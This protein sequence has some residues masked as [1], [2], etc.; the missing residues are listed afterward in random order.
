MLQSWP[1][2][3]LDGVTAHAQSVTVT[4]TAHGLEVRREG[5]G[6]VVWPY[7]DVSQTQGNYRG[8]HVRLERGREPAEAIIVDD[9]AF[10]TQL[11]KVAPRAAGRFHNPSSR[12]RRPAL[13]VMALVAAIALGAGI[14]FWAIPATATFVAEQVPVAWEEEL[15]RTVANAMIGS[16]AKCTDREVTRTVEDIVTRLAATVPAN[17]YTFRVSVIADET[18]NA[19]AAPGGHIVV[20]AGLLQRTERAEELAGVLAHEISHVVRRHGTKSL[21][22]SVAT[23]VFLSAVAGDASGAMSVVLESAD[24]LSSL[25][26]S[27]RAEDE[28]DLDGL[29]M[30]AAAR[31]D[32]HGLVDFFEKLRKKKAKTD[33]EYLRYL[34]TH[35]LT[36]DRIA[37]L[38]AEPSIESG[39]FAPLSSRTKWKKIVASCGTG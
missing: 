36:S 18:M 9:V 39:P 3:Y 27:R 31:I 10:L 34:S 11:Y 8:E 33:A 7:A 17:P 35:P 38:K 32:P 2:R 25:H 16:T 29:K 15:G 12:A 30:L 23:S 14:Y 24:T 1:A 21:F 37:R 19:F 22:R 20:Y 5:G 26:Y 4:P 28:A 13:V 6:T